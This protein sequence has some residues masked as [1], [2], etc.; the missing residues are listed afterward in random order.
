M[1][2]INRFVLSLFFTCIL[3][4]GNCSDSKSTMSEAVPTSSTSEAI[5]SPLIPQKHINILPP[6]GGKVFLLGA[7]QSNA[8]WTSGDNDPDE[9]EQSFKNR[10]EQKNTNWQ[11][12][13][14]NW[15]VTFIGT[16]VRR[17]SM[18]DSITYRD[19]FHKKKGFVETYEGNEEL[20]EKYKD[21]PYTFGFE[22]TSK[23]GIV[24]N[25]SKFLFYNFNSPMFQKY[26]DSCKEENDFYDF[27]MPDICVLGYMDLTAILQL[28]KLL[29]PIGKIVLPA[30][31]ISHK[32]HD[33]EIVFDLKDPEKGVMYHKE[34][35]FTFQKLKAKKSREEELTEEEEEI[36]NSIVHEK[37]FPYSV[38]RSDFYKDIQGI[39]SYEQFHGQVKTTI[40]HGDSSWEIKWDITKTPDDLE[41]M[42]AKTREEIMQL[43]DIA[44]KTEVIASID[45]DLSTLREAFEV[46]A[47]RLTIGNFTKLLSESSGRE[48][49]LQ[50]VPFGSVTDGINQILLGRANKRY[51]PDQPCLIISP[52]L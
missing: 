37:G 28:P 52:K 22:F 36:L 32:H 49:Q 7:L 35:C 29:S 12:L 27:I 14:E 11:R 25:P 51:K 6:I 33:V 47:H 17:G 30:G 34:P 8:Y 31:D 39:K 23:E 2:T 20:D 21:F 38:T 5:T 1:S 43:P 41:Q 48:V 15:A 10:V 24:K 19:Y 46:L 45:K 4:S 13:G 44:G 18:H 16:W 42:F 40:K 9:D 50:L 26:A 3:F